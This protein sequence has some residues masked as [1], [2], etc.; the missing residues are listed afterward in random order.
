MGTAAHE[1]RKWL[2]RKMW[3]DIYMSG[4]VTPWWALTKKDEA[5]IKFWRKRGYVEED[6]PMLRLTETG[7][8]HYCKTEPV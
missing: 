5:A 1:Y 6:G 4:W 3:R 8:A 7:R 2:A